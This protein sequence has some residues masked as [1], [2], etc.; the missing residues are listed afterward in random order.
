M[1]MLEVMNIDIHVKRTVLMV[2]LN[3]YE[4]MM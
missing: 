4:D 3:I 2:Q 1:Y